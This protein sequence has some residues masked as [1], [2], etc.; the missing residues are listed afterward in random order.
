M[1]RKKE[2]PSNNVQT[3]TVYGC[4]MRVETG[5]CGQ[6]VAP[7]E[8]AIH[9]I[10]HYQDLCRQKREKLNRHWCLKHGTGE[11][12]SE[13][14]TY[15][16]INNLQRLSDNGRPSCIY[17][18]SGFLELGY[19]CSACGLLTSKVAQE[20][21]YVLARR[22]RIL[23]TKRTIEDMISVP[24]TTNKDDK[25]LNIAKEAIE[26]LIR[27]RIAL[28][29]A[30]DEIMNGVEAILNKVHPLSNLLSDLK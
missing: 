18:A 28:E 25:S 16:P 20:K 1:Y 15:E 26:T 2:L 19:H 23:R 13:K 7:L 21:A 10:Q 12:E 4:R 27:K 11:C 30:E 9:C 22:N 5:F 8:N 29:K 14:D 6:I 24:T 3:A 17:R